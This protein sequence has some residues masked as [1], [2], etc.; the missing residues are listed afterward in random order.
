MLHSVFAAEPG[1]I[2]VVH[3][4]HKDFGWDQEVDKGINYYKAKR[5][6]FGILPKDFFNQYK[7]VPFYMNAKHHQGDN[8]N[9]R[10][11]G[12]EIIAKLKEN[13][14]VVTIICDD[15]ALEFVAKPLFDNN[16]YKF[17]FW[18]VN[19]DPRSYGVVN[20]Y[21][22]PEHNVTGVISEHPFYYTL[23]LA[24]QIIPDYKDIYAFFDKSPT[25]NGI[26]DNFKRQIEKLDPTTSSHLK[27]IIITNNWSLWKKTILNHQ[28]KNNIFVFG[29]L[30]TLRDE[31]GKLLT[32]KEIAGWLKKHSHVPDLTILTNHIAEGFL[33]A[34]SNPGFVHGYE[35]SEKAAQIIQGIAI[36]EIPVEVPQH[37]AVHVNMSRAKQLKLNVPVEI[38]AMS[39][40]FKEL[41]Y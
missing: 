27:A 7:I 33:L 16:K 15:E 13:N 9:L 36:N 18:G 19:N 25:G 11:K 1:Y 17:V 39:K 5:K 26:L 29:S 30:Y 10:N 38:I 3:S 24:T 4:Y 41:G 28:D 22:A 35:A 31:K 23:R 20:N 32:T 12:Q 34:I 8:Q 6:L 37:K 14:P 40:I 2:A 21:N